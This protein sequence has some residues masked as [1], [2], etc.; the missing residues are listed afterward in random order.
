M[1]STTTTT[2]YPNITRINVGQSDVRIQFT[3]TDSRQSR[4]A[5]A[6]DD[7]NDDDDGDVKDDDS[8]DDGDD[9]DTTLQVQLSPKHHGRYRLI[10]FS[11]AFSFSLMRGLLNERFLFSHGKYCIYYM[12]FTAFSMDSIP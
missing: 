5:H 9:G 6:D 7:D 11:L 12:V 8:D 1:D 4:G 2:L 10:C 3:N